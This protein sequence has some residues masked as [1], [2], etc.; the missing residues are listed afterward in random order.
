VFKRERE[1]V[2]VR[3]DEFKREAVGPLSC[4]KTR[5]PWSVPRQIFKN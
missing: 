5:T 1:A 3:D 4:D 2:N